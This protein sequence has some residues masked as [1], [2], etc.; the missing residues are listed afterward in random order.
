[1]ENYIMT[2]KGELLSMEGFIKK[3][4]FMN[5]IKE[6]F[7]DFCD[8]CTGDCQIED[9]IRE[10]EKLP[11]TEAVSLTPAAKW[12][13]CSDGYYPYCSNCKSEPQSR[14][15]TDYCPTCGAWMKGDKK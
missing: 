12:E 13:I 8:Y 4:D 7:C 11:I 3:S 14:I 1:M 9:V 10:V 15:M 5:M 6:D 2:F